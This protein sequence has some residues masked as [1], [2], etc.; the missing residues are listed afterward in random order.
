[1]QYAIKFQWFYSVRVPKL[2]SKL[3]YCSNIEVTLYALETMIV[4][5]FSQSGTIFYIS[6]DS[7]LISRVKIF[8]LTDIIRIF[9]NVIS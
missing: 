3:Q 5:L 9:T 6:P 7:I 2:Y 1:M 8:H 4:S